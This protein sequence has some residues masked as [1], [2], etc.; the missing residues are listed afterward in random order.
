MPSDSSTIWGGNP[1]HA[2]ASLSTSSVFYYWAIV[3]HYFSILGTNVNNPKS[4][5][6]PPPL[7]P[8]LLNVFIH[9]SKGTPPPTCL[10]MFSSHL[11][12]KLILAEKVPVRKRWCTHM[13]V[14]CKEYNK[15]L[16]AKLRAGFSGMTMNN[17]RLP[18]YGIHLLP[19][20]RENE[21]KGRKSKDKV[22]WG[23]HTLLYLDAWPW[24][25]PAFDSPTIRVINFSL[26]ALFPSFLAL[27]FWSY[28]A[29]YQYETET[30]GVI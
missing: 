22:W 24:T 3:R 18:Q 13:R 10:S 16:F 30:I 6:F 9:K 4:W 21:A 15:S 27:Q 29:G 19:Q 7:F 1:K 2:Q 28:L 12:K 25:K 5:A 23:G 26:L 17:P 8:A 11:S 20:V 14:I